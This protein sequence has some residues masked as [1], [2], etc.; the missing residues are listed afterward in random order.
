MQLDD[1]VLQALGK[2]NN[3]IGSGHDTIGWAIAG[4]DVFKTDDPGTYKLVRVSTNIER[5]VTTVAE[6]LQAAYE[7]GDW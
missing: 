7:D 3:I 6:F 5:L 2:R 1:K 4:Y